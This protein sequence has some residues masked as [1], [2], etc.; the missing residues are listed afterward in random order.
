MK[1]TYI[2]HSCFLAESDSACLLFD[3]FKGTLPEI[4]RNKPLYILASHAHGDHFS[5]VI[6]SLAEAYP[7]AVYLLSY[8]I[9][10]SSVPE[11]LRERTHFLQPRENWGD[12]VLSVQTLRST[13]EGIAFWCK[14]DG[15][16]IYH[17]GDLN[18]WY[19]E[20]EDEQWNRDMTASYRAEIGL[21]C[22]RTADIA[23]LPVDPRLEQWFYLGIDDFM[24][25]VDADVI[26]PMHFW[27]QFDVAQRLKALECSEGYRDRIAEVYE[28]GQ[29]FSI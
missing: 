25:V 17:A 10:V 4:P 26:I 13:D 28:K 5:P 14:L 15:R 12:G 16:D 18:H 24:K 11:A 3:Y 22:G 8:D 1:I 7:S 29:T 20:G 19:W 23:F 27:G 21:L 2:H 9:P 6:F